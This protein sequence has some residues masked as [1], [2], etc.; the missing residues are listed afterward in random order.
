MEYPS[1]KEIKQS[2]RH[3]IH[4]TFK[5]KVVT[6][7][8]KNLFY[9][10]VDA[11]LHELCTRSQVKIENRDF[12]HVKRRTSARQRAPS[13]DPDIVK[14]LNIEHAECIITQGFIAST[15]DGH[16]CLLGR[17]GSDTSAALFASLIGAERLEIWTDVIIYLHYNAS[18]VPLIYYSFM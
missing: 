17:G 12:S 15:A 10:F 8:V 14:R 7:H 2:E 16:T 1:I 18:K 11:S 13:Y 6:H 4:D 9:K 3:L 5:Y